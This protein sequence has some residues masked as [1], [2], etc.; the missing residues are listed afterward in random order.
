MFLSRIGIKIITK[1][2]TLTIEAKTMVTRT[3]SLTT[4]RKLAIGGKERK[5]QSTGET[6][7]LLKKPR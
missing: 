3:K 2:A 5:I 6:I 7:N 4:S 1:I